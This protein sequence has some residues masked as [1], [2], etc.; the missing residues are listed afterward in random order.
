M[1]FKKVLHK[2]GQKHSA[3]YNSSDVKL[4]VTFKNE[5]KIKV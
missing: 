4:T 2:N 1:K 5:H 3:Q